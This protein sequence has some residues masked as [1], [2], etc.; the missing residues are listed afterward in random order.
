MTFVFG[1][2]PDNIAEADIKDLL[3]HYKLLKIE[4]FKKSV[5]HHHSLYE[6]MVTVDI[7]DPVMGSL[8]EQHY[9]H[10]CWKGICI[11]VHRLIF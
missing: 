1:N 6:C 10:L 7:K 11:N 5:P 9:N 8:F 4:F 3:H 2:L